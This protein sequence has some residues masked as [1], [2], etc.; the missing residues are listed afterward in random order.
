MLL[1]KKY[2]AIQES[3]RAE[4]KDTDQIEF[5]YPQVL[6]IMLATGAK[7]DMADKFVAIFPRYLYL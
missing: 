7:I 4:K 3:Y 2:H 5:L 1:K 6:R